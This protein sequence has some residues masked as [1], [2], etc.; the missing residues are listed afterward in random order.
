MRI[1]LLEEIKTQ[2][3][4]GYTFKAV[5]IKCRDGIMWYNFLASVSKASAKSF[6]NKIKALEVHKKTGCKI[7][8][9]AEI[10]N[11]MIRKW[12]IL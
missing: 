7:D 11:P 9:I 2:N 8:I 10:L 5:H 1:N 3:F 12:A 4:P 6:R